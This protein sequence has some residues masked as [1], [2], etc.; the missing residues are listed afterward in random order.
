VNLSIGKIKGDAQLE[1]AKSRERIDA[2]AAAVFAVRVLMGQEQPAS[3][4]APDSYTVRI[5]ENTQP[6]KQDDDGKTKPADPN[7][8]KVK[9]KG[10]GEIKTLP[11]SAAQFLIANG[12]AER[13]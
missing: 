13:V 8:I 11:K 3:Q 12:S 7:S 6:V 5:L 1:K 4:H 10:S 9:M 2:A